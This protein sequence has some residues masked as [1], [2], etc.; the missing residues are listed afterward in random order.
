MIKVKYKREQP[1]IKDPDRI[2]TIC[3]G[4]YKAVSPLQKTCSKECRAKLY[5]GSRA[6][7]Y[8]SNPDAIKTYNQRRKDKDPDVWKN[9]YRKE[10]EEVIEKL[11]GKCIACEVTN[12]NWLHIDYIP[13]MI[14]TG[15][16][17]PRHKKWVLDNIKDF[18]LLCANHH[19]ELTLTGKIEG[20][21]IVQKTKC[22]NLILKTDGTI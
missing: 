11:G 3:Q 4:S 19:Y 7:F 2:C 16:R 12:P 22:N 8:E 21:L 15:Y 20:T 10:R 5:T 13:T 18:R 17:H 6:K 9:K 14:G 1:T